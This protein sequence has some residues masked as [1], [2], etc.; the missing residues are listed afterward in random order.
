MNKQI[1]A[2]G[3]KHVLLIFVFGKKFEVLT[4]GC[5]DEDES[6]WDMMPYRLVNS[7]VYD[8]LLICNFY[9][10]ARHH[11]PEDLNVRY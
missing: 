9:Q 7:V 8:S 10:T 2:A 4:A 11:T 6:F 5:F 1:A 3:E